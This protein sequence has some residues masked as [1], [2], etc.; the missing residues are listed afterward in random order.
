MN[1]A[2]PRWISCAALRAPEADWTRVSS[3][4]LDLASAMPPHCFDDFTAAFA[5]LSCQTPTTKT[6]VRSQCGL[7]PETPSLGVQVFSDR[8]VAVAARAPPL[9][10]G[11]EKLRA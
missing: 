10:A 4:Q 1:S 5:A 7:S 11:V 2:L 6:P 3:W 8:Q 9:S